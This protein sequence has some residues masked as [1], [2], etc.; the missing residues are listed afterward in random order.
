MQ[1]QGNI[2]E[3]GHYRWENIPEDPIMSRIS[4]HVYCAY[5]M[6]FGREWRRGY[7]R[8]HYDRLY[9][10]ESGEA[11]ISTPEQEVV[12][13]P[14]HCYLLG[15]NLLHR[16]SCSAGIILHWCHFQT[17][18]D[19][20]VDLFQEIDVPLEACPETASEYR[21]LFQSLEKTMDC[22]TACCHLLR[23]ALL[24][25]L[26][27]PHLQLAAPASR[28][29]AEER[30]RFLPVLKHI[31]T[32]LHETLRVT[33]LA[34]LLGLNPEYFSRFFRKYFRIPPKKYILQKRIQHAQKLLCQTALQ[35]Q[36]VGRRCGF[37]DPYHFSK[38]FRNTAGIPPSE[39]RQRYQ[40]QS[41]PPPVD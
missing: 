8:T 35:V 33:D 17:L 38:T 30:Q 34:G 18:L 7:I 14:G 36:E 31:D 29:M 20:S 5:R 13:R 27:Q 26:I 37:P 11:T 15:S 28:Q 1:N 2:E 40:K 19:G 25:Q 10:V 39:Y 9:F 12:L 3:S 32:H 23:S 21:D 41:V 22:R 6:E 4:V 24:L 16:H